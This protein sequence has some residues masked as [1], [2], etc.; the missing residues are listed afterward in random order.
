MKNLFWVLILFLCFFTSDI[1]LAQEI[2]S[3][4]GKW[5]FQIDRENVG[6]RERWFEKKLNDEIMLP[7]SMA[8]QHKGDDVT[9][10]TKWTGSIYDSSFYFNPALEK[11][12]QPGNIHIPFW[13]TPVKHYVGAAW[14]QREII[15]PKAWTKKR[16]ELYLERTHIETRLW[17]N[18]REV[19]LQNSLVAPHIYDISTYLLTGKNKITLRVD[20]EIKE[21]NV[22]PDSH[23]ISDHTQGNWNGIIGEISLQAKSKVYI[24]EVQVYP[25]LLNKKA[26][27]KL[28]L[29]NSTKTNLKGQ[30]KL[31]A[32]S[33]N[34]SKTHKPNTIHHSISVA[35]SNELQID[36]PLGND[37]LIWDEFDPALYKLNVLLSSNGESDSREIQFGMREFKI[38]GSQ[39]LINNRPVFLRG[40]LHNCEFPLTG[41][42]S[43]R[44]DE[45]ERIF[46]KVKSYGLNHVRFHSWCPPEAAFIAADLVGLFLQP[47]APSWPNHGPKIGLGQPVDQYLYDE[48]NRIAKQYGNYASFVMFSAGNEP[49]GNQVAYLNK[50]VDS[51]KEKDSRRVYTGMSVGGSWPVVPNAEF[52]VRGGLRGLL[53]NKMPE[54]YSDFTAAL[55]AFQVPFIAHENGQYCV[56]PNFEEISQY[57]GAYRAKNMEMFQQILADN[58]MA[59]LAKDFLFAS[60][61]LQTLAYKHDVERILRTPRY[62]GF[63]LLGL[64][65][66]PG[67]G[68]ALVGVLNAFWQEKGYTSAEEYTKFTN[69][70]VPL[71]KFPKFVFTTNEKLS[72]D[73]AL[74]H[75]GKEPLRNTQIDWVI[76]DKDENIFQKGTFD[77]KDYEIA[78]GI[79]VGKIQV[80]LTNIN[81][82]SQF[83]LEVSVKQFKNDWNF[84][85][86]PE[87]QRVEN[88]S[89][90]Y[91]NALD[92]KT[93]KI[94]NEGGKVFL[95]VSGKVMKGKEVE[96]HFLPVFWNTSWFKMRPPH[97]TGMLIKNQHKAFENFPTSY[98]SDLQW[99]DIQHKSQ[100]MNLEDFPVEFRPI[101]QPIDTW[102]FSRRLGLLFEARVGKGRIVVSSG[103]LRADI[104]NRPASRQLYHSI[105]QY[106]NSEDFTPKDHIEFN[107]IKDLLTKESRMKIIDYTKDSPDELKPNSNQNR[108]K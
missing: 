48:S 35:E 68:S 49:A 3:L 59:D 80:D 78:N 37:M 47:E 23:S 77:G 90:Y 8:E 19:G 83:N 14:Y 66:F 24:D 98:H 82:A 50:F 73:V 102:F 31:T 21:I 105:I 4:E 9:L 87:Q 43:M 74:F 58:H 54:T 40:T 6:I 64:Q 92:E 65:D 36:L 17:I 71:A 52:Q 28:R 89:V 75:S 5:Q 108:I 63:Q 86:Y 96:M 42:P 33:F 30:L 13:L 45:W 88:K 57:T 97:V 41:Y 61:K 18:N 69:E 38:N 2:K 93:E 67:Q 104:E 26:I 1:I 11:F 55:D 7:G 22:G 79:P 10:K 51:W 46:R 106:M 39:F 16:V 12:R 20:N 103:D 85:V 15:I 60:G 44:A 84:W 53:W 32:Q 27:V 107:I 72:V 99:W 100:V 95:N 29:V 101:I 62:S 91:T 25:D 70:T 34:S 56:F 81:K 76:K 94:L